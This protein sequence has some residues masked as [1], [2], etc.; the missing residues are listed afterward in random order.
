MWTAAERKR[1]TLRN[2]NENKTT[3]RGGYNYKKVYEPPAAPTPPHPPL[4]PKE[5]FRIKVALR[6]AELK[7]KH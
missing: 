2:A 4:P 5:A 7:Q 6:N 3:R 1:A